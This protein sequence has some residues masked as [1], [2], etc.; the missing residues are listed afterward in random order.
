MQL[1]MD[2]HPTLMPVHKRHRK[3]Q[4]WMSTWHGGCFFGEKDL[5]GLHRMLAPSEKQ[6]FV[7]V[8]SNRVTTWSPP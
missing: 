2:R 1:W 7:C 6:H 5:E 4:S 3:E 8:Q